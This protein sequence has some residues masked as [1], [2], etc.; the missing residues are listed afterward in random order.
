MGSGF[1]MGYSVAVF[2]LH[3]GHYCKALLE[4]DDLV[5]SEPSALTLTLE[6]N[7]ILPLDSK[8][9]FLVDKGCFFSPTLRWP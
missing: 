2:V 8:K 9:A 1:L 5:T 7:P 4:P 6:V 3:S